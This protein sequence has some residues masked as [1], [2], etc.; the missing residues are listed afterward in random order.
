MGF[1]STFVTSDNSIKWPDW[2]KEKYKDSV[3]FDSCASSK[4]EDKFYFSWSS[5]IQDFSK[6]LNDVNFFDKNDGHLHLTILILHECDGVTRYQ[7]YKDK[8]ICS[9]PTPF[10]CWKKQKGITHHYCYECQQVGD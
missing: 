1:R 8:I 5:L 6:A 10:N 9:E 3:N 2:L 7:I 4:M